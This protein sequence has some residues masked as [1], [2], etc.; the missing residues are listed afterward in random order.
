MSIAY[1]ANNANVSNISQVV[2]IRNI[3]KLESK[4][5]YDCENLL[6]SI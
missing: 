1:N 6:T 4:I 2:Q 5:N 3:Y